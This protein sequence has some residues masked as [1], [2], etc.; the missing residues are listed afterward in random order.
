M[1]KTVY[2]N[3]YDILDGILSLHCNGKFDA[4]IS[5]GNGVFYKGQA[6]P[7]FKYDIQPQKRDVIEASSV[8]LPHKDSELNS[9]VFDPPFLT[10]IK[11]GREHDSIMAKRF[12]GYW[13]YKELEEHYRGTLKECARILKNKGVLVFK[14]QDIVH[15][16]KLHATHINVVNWAQEF[17]FRLKDCFILTAKNRMP[18]VGNITQQHARIHHSYFLVLE[19]RK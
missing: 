15:N 12:G 9:I 5:Y 8:A 7:T 4:D 18:I 19:V 2:E 3:Q 16:H 1:I 17:G 11:S 14:C 6:E 13:N 10:Y